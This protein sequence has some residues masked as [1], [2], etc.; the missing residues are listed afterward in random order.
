MITEAPQ[1][2]SPID[3]APAWRR[4]AICIAIGTIGS[5]GMWSFVVSLPAVQEGFGVSR[6]AASLPYTMTMLGFAFGGVLMGK[7][8]DRYGIVPPLAL[9]GLL[10]GIGYAAA[11]LA[12]NLTLYAIAQL[13]VGLGTSASFAPLMVDI[14]RWFVK[15][16]GIAVAIAGSGNYLAGM[17]WP[18][19]M[20]Y[21]IA[22][23][24]WRPVHLAIGLVCVSTLVPAAFLMR[25]RPPD[26][27]NANAIPVT[28]FGAIEMPQR[29]LLLLLTFAGV[30]C[31]VAMSMPQVHLVAYCADLGYGAARGAQMLSLMLGL[32]IISRVLSGLVADKIG[33]LATLLLGSTLQGIALF[34]YLF[35]DGLTSLYIISGMFG[36]FQGGLVP[37]YA[38]IVREYFPS[39]K[40]GGT[41]GI[42]IMA[43][44]FGMALGGW[45]SGYIYDVT[46]SY[47]L[48]FL[49]GMIWNLFNVAVIAFLIFRRKP[50]ATVAA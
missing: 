32:G 20:Q 1:S 12:P 5:I 28:R 7:I 48:A 14:S 35:F 47:H 38:V 8:A 3:T 49:N 44:L 22:T 46:G 18:P 37:M 21:F 39:S 10:L 11:S 2:T 24:G 9:G 43:T 19:I 23:Q 45:M 50:A 15:R 4:L 30:A 42:I 17:V 31:C 16:R 34:L 41:L 33:G 27:A 40:A 13:V 26:E 6:G 36:L 29:T 25:Q